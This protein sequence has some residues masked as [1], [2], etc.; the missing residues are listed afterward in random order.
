MDKNE[1]ELND[2]INKIETCPI[3]LY[4]YLNQQQL[5]CYNN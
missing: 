1:E 3:I 2:L 5:V 4:I